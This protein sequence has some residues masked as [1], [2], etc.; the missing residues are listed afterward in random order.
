[1]TDSSPKLT[2]ERLFSDPPLAG[3]VP[4]DLRFTPDGRAVTYLAAA[5][6]DGER[7]DLWRMA[8]SD[9]ATDV[10]LNARDLRATSA[11][12]TALSA[13]E[14]AERERRRQFSH[15]ITQYLWR[16]KTAQLIVPMDGQIFLVDTRDR[17]REVQTLCPESTRQ[18]A[19]QCSPSG[20]Y[21]SFVRDGDLYIL[22]LSNS[23]SGERQ[24][25]ADATATVQ[26]GLA[27]FLAAEEM[28]R[29]EGHWWMPDESAVLF[30]R[31]DERTVAPSLRIEIDATG[32]RPV[33]QRYPY[34]GKDNPQVELWRAEVSGR[35]PTCLWRADET[36]C[37]LARVLCHETGVYVQ[38]QNRPQQR[39]HYKRYVGGEWV[40]LHTEISETWV[41]LTN[42]WRVLPGG[43]LFFTSEQSGHRCG[44]L[45]QPDGDVQPVSGPT[46]INQVLA[47]HK[48][49]V[50]VTGWQDDPTQNHLFRL[51]LDGQASIKLTDAPGWHD[52]IVS[53]SGG[54]FVDRFSSPA[55][56]VQIWCQPL[57]D[58]QKR[59]LLHAQ[60]HTDGHPYAPFAV[61]H[62]QPDYGSLTGR[63]GHRLHYRVT[64]PTRIVG[65]HP[66]VIY[67]YGGPGAQKVK[68]EW[69][70]LLLQLFAH[71]GFGVLELDNRGSSNRGR[72]FE[73][74][75]YENMGTIEVEDQVLGLQALERYPWA[76]L[77]RVGVF[78]HSYGGY[79]T[80]MCL[81][82]APQQFS[83]GVA[84]APV[85]DWRLYDSHYTERY[86]GKPDDNPQV[87]AHANVLTHL[88]NL[89]APLLL[90]H[91]MADDNVLFTHSTMIMSKLQSLNTPFELMTY[92]GAKHGMQERDVS[93]HRFNAILDFF[94]RHLGLSAK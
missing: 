87:Y 49:T 68:Q 8:L 58:P 5:N 9:G 84:V 83:A 90:M 48:Q 2:V 94:A 74:P 29:F 41:N 38:T 59:R 85:S 88:E 70:P 24:L 55:E 91:G 4:Q 20:R 33:E 53:E 17:H 56:P 36:D 35:P 11:D 10:L 31:V 93:I 78:G 47:R 16:K 71:H 26:N 39:L 21:I 44:Y 18:S 30:C 6:D 72:F 57:A 73:A 3:R 51:S 7:L 54:V 13:A 52:P 27:D 66:T 50:Y 1:M 60:R 46:H 12:V 34:A 69:G 77:D 86:M 63:H 15:G 22:D 25:T 89:Q 92:P 19:V 81:C 45:R 14:R 23:G 80:L 75:L 65:Q 64:P 37:Y 28:H 61:R 79:L 32:A 40:G 82:K 67:V 42:D 62:A 76:D 43:A